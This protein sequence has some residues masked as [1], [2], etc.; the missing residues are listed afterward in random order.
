MGPQ[1]HGSLSYGNFGIPTWESRDKWHLG[2]GPVVKHKIHYKGEGGG[3]PQVRAVLSLMNLVNPFCPWLIYAL[4]CY[5][6]ALTNLLFGLC[7]SMWVSEVF[8]NL[9]SP[10]PK[11]QHTLLPLKCC[12]LTN[13]PN[14]FSFCCLHLSTHNWVHQ[15]A[16]WYYIIN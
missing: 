9:L 8:V 4:K 2:A 15:G 7:R 6:Y 12:N 16:W 11:L 14:S 1:N 13:V 3:F 5:N 10:I